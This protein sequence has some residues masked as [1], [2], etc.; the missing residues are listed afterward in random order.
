VSSSAPA[1]VASAPS[2]MIASMSPGGG[3]VG[4]WFALSSI[5]YRMIGP[6][7]ALTVVVGLVATVR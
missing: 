3:G 1:A 5:R 7:Q 6:F 2:C 4:G